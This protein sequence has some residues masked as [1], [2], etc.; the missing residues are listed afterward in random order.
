M[1]TTGSVSSCLS[2]V[3]AE[4]LDGDNVELSEEEGRKPGI[5]LKTVSPG[6]DG[7]GGGIPSSPLIAMHER[8]RER[9]TML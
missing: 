5:S 7:G 3:W 9:L 4:G 1:N 2:A 8:G 6:T